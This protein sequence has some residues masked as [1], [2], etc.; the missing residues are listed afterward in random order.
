MYFVFY[1]RASPPAAGPLSLVSDWFAFWCHMASRYFLDSVLKRQVFEG[2]VIG[3]L[4]FWKPNPGILE[5][6]GSIFGV[7]GHHF[8][9]SLL[10]QGHWGLPTRHLGAQILIFVDF[11]SILGSHGTHLEVILLSLGYHICSMGWGMDFSVVRGWKSW[12]DRM[13]GF[14]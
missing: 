13:L 1:P 3:W 8:D 10:I 14:V 9:A 4:A 12:Q 6:W 2:A 11:W 5:A 7:L